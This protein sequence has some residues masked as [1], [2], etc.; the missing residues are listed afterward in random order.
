MDLTSNNVLGAGFRRK[1]AVFFG[2]GDIPRS[3]IMNPRKLTELQ[4]NEYLSIE[5]CNLDLTS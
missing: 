1:A 2:Q 3:F 4:K 5:I